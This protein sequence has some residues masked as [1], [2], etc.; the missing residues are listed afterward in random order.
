M[1]WRLTCHLMLIA[2]MS[3]Y[4]YYD[5]LVSC[6]TSC[7][8]KFSC[9]SRP[10]GL[11]AVLFCSETLLESSAALVP[12]L[13]E[14]SKRTPFRPL[15]VSL[16]K[17]WEILDL[18]RP[19]RFLQFSDVDPPVTASRQNTLSTVTRS[20]AR[21]AGGYSVLQKKGQSAAY[22]EINL[23]ALENQSNVLLTVKILLEIITAHFYSKSV[24]VHFF[25]LWRLMYSTLLRIIY[26]MC[27]L[28]II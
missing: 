23:G 1:S 10:L 15:I 9:K 14:L 2:I 24:R 28:Y 17:F 11:R 4:A 8:T 19:S 26:A 12:L 13:L 7:V 18:R 16:I 21:S 5:G 25:T 22:N 6:A 3:C 27:N 20:R